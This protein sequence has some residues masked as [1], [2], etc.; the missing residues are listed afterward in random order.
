MTLASRIYT[1]AQEN[2]FALWEVCH[3]VLGLRVNNLMEETMC[4]HLRQSAERHFED[5]PKKRLPS[6][7]KLIKEKTVGTLHGSKK[8]Y[9]LSF[10]GRGRKKTKNSQCVSAIAQTLVE[11]DLPGKAYCSLRTYTASYDTNKPVRALI[12]SVTVHLA[13]KGLPNCTVYCLLHPR[14]VYFAVLQPGLFSVYCLIHCKTARR[15]TPFSELSQALCWSAIV[16]SVTRAVVYVRSIESM[17]ID[18]CLSLVCS[19]G[20]KS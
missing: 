20:R 17:G 15:R 9:W 8:M 2:S 12:R 14:L 10:F 1:V 7:E 16:F 11:I 3:A 19:L 4:S 6:Q 13:N 5:W 18:L